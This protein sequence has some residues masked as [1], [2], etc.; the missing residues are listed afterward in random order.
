[1]DDVKA[2]AVQFESIQGD[3]PANLETIRRF[4]AQA[5]ARGVQ[6][7][8]FPECCITGYWF[9]RKLSREQLGKLA[10]PVNGP[11]SAALLELASRYGMTIGAGFIQAGAD[12]YYNTYLVPMPDGGMDRH[13]KLHA[14]E[15]VP[16]AARDE[17]T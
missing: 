11:S 13:R 17:F 3:K 9:L 10:E 16:L 7:L 14:F 6:L 4:T 12:L 15:N 2:A 1:M 5:A 8:V